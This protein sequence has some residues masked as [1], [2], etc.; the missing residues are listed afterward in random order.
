MPRSSVSKSIA[1]GVAPG[2]LGKSVQLSKFALG[3][4]AV[5]GR[6]SA[7]SVRNQSDESGLQVHISQ[8]VL[9]RLRQGFTMQASTPA[10]LTQVTNTG[11]V[12]FKKILC[13]NRGEIAIRIF[14]AGTELGL[15][16]V[17]TGCK[18]PWYT[19]LRTALTLER[20]GM[21]AASYI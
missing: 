16:T 21:P 20:P 3:K 17:S 19:V 15:R 13:A 10:C 11:E 1:S 7:V 6:R 2:V 4:A 9:R 18:Q 12:P 8:L 14:R 5:P